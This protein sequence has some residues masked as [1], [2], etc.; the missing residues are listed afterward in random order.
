MGEL[1]KDYIL[2]DFVLVSEKRGQRP[3]EFKEEDDLVEPKTCFFCPGSE[4]L[5]PPEVGRISKENGWSIRWFENKFSGVKEEGQFEIKTD[6]KY[7][8]YSSNYG[9]HEI[10]VNTNDHNKQVCDLSVPELSDLFKV[11]RD[12]IKE[13]SSRDHIKYVSIF[14]NHGSK[15]G[16]SIIHSHSQIIAM[17]QVPKRIVRKEEAVAKFDSCPYCE[18]LKIEK[19][20]YRRCFENNTFVAFTPYASRFNY[21]IWVMPKNHRVSMNELSEEEFNDLSD[22]MSK[23][24]KRLATMNASYNYYLQYSPFNDLHFHIE[25]CPRIATWGGFELDTEVIFNV[26]SPETAAKFYRGEE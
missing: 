26:I 24:L 16:T 19:D 17:N 18:I 11:Y 15:A 25:V 4:D 20:S 13:I 14:K 23:L 10:I 2:D 3:H 22:I 9:Y 6:N 7:F 5:T 21:E 12:R 8:T 1:R